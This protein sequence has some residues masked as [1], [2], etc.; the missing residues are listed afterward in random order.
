MPTKLADNYFAVLAKHFEKGITIE[1]LALSK[2]QKLRTLQVLEVFNAM[3]A[4]PWIDPQEYLRNKY[5]R[6]PNELK[7]DMLILNFMAQYRNKGTREVDEFRV[8]AVANQAIKHGMQTGNDDTALKGAAL[9]TKI[10]QLDKPATEVNDGELL[11]NAQQFTTDVSAVYENKR[12]M[13]RK[14]MQRL[15]KQYGVIP[16]EW[17]QQLEIE[18]AEIIEEEEVPLPATVPAGSPAGEAQG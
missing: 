9:L 12:R 13:S 10:A 6:T 1:R 8:R 17:M 18:D 11:P 7:N 4:R 16:D 14:E 5:N 2:S 3:C 15:R